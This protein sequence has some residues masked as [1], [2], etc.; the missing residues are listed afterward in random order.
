MIRSIFLLIVSIGL[1]M[2]LSESQPEAE[3]DAT[4]EPIEHAGEVMWITIPDIMTDTRFSFDRY[5][6]VPAR[7]NSPKK[8]VNEIEIVGTVRG[9]RSEIRLGIFEDVADA[10]ASCDWLFSDVA[11]VA[12]PIMKGV[13]ESAERITI[14]DESWQLGSSILFLKGRTL[15]SVRFGGETRGDDH[16]DLARA[17]ADAIHFH[18]TPHVIV[19]FEGEP[20]KTEDDSLPPPAIQ[21]AEVRNPSNPLHAKA[22]DLTWLVDVRIVGAESAKLFCF[23]FHQGCLIYGRTVV[24]A[25]GRTRVWGD[26][27]EAQYLGRSGD[28][29]MRPAIGVE[30]KLRWG[31]EKKLRI[32]RQRTDEQN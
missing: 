31:E 30:E 21:H 16:L 27:A 11:A 3:D 20:P 5:Y 2:I 8:I 14:G 7:Q 12:M 1:A 29:T 4:G 13:G 26:S 22:S 25:R 17:T 19:T 18:P 28:V 32:G 15:C 24:A 10:K 6:I 9:Q 23:E